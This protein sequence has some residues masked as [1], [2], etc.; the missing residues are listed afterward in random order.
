[1][2]MARILP[3]FRLIKESSEARC[4]KE[5]NFFT[6]RAWIIMQDVN[7]N[8]SSSRIKNEKSLCFSPPLLSLWQFEISLKKETKRLEINEMMSDT[9][10][11]SFAD[12]QLFVVNCRL[13]LCLNLWW[14]VF[15]PKILFPFHSIS[16]S[17]AF[18]RLYFLA[19]PAKCQ[20]IASKKSHDLKNDPQ[21]ACCGK[22]KGSFDSIS[23]I[24][25][26]F[27]LR[28]W[29]YNVWKAKRKY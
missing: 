4:W 21:R 7:F 8:L 17:F 10:Q 2:K 6:V 1:M 5:W 29:L 27:L 11:P 25:K 20:I 28:S 23:A 16:I 22:N 15:H 3:F 19:N 26:F 24:K 12:W 13:L 9:F 14:Y 18:K